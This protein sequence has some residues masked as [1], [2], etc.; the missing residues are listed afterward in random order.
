MCSLQ[1]EIP[2]KMGK[3]NNSNSKEDSEF[4]KIPLMKKH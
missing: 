3:V 2:N 1:F 4:I